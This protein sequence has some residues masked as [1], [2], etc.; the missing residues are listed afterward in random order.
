MQANDTHADTAEHDDDRR[1]MVLYLLT[2]VGGAQ[3]LWSVD[4]LGRELESSEAA[5]IAVNELLRAGLAY[6]TSDGFVFAS[7]A[8]IVAVET[9]GY[10]M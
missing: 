1:R 2:G 9:T 3:P 7:R 10:A 5:D 6:R 4:D 8:G